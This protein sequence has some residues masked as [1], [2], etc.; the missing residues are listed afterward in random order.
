MKN[1]FT[2]AL[3]ALWL[4]CP[5]PGRPDA[6]SAGG[7]V[8][9]TGGGA[10][11]GGSTGG[12]AAGG[13]ATAGGNGSDGGTTTDAGP[14]VRI[15]GGLPPYAIRTNGEAWGMGSMPL[16]QFDGDRPIDLQADVGFIL[17]RSDGGVGYQGVGS[18][19]S[20]FVG[21][22]KVSAGVFHACAVMADRSVK[23]VSDIASNL[24]G[25]VGNGTNRPAVVAAQV[26]G[27]S[28]ARALWLGLARSCALLVD[29]TVACWGETPGNGS[30]ES[31]VAVAV[32]G[33]TGVTSIDGSWK[34]VCA[35]HG[36]D[37]T[38]CWGDV[39]HLPV[40]S[41]GGDANLTPME[42]PNLQGAIEVKGGRDHQCALFSSGVVKCWGMRGVISSFQLGLDEPLPQE[43]TEPVQVPGITDGV[44]LSA[45][46]DQTCVLRRSGVVTCWGASWSSPGSILQDQAPL[47]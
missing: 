24:N 31:N 4:G 9:A 30:A 45:A 25:E 22:V 1:T 36:G 43:S 19:G 40:V 33:L 15:T 37:R 38:S 28:T 29:G 16:V 13:A 32:A 17:I 46:R 39:S 44:H 18:D 11:A 3:V 27:V 6:G 34:I 8:A 35:H 5:G 14:I 26:M 42:F 2:I 47:P 10:T 41:D 12:G 7:G 21:A 23:C 20:S